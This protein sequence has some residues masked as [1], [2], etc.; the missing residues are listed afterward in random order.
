MLFDFFCL[1]VFPTGMFSRQFFRRNVAISDEMRLLCFAHER[2][3]RFY[4]RVLFFQKTDDVKLIRFVPALF[5]S[6]M[7]YRYNYIDFIV[8]TS[9]FT[10]KYKTTY[11]LFQIFTS[12]IVEFGYKVFIRFSEGVIFFINKN[13]F[14]NSGI[15]GAFFHRQTV[16][17]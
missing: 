11:L 17:L 12:R 13:V 10:V 9:V 3:T 15:V 2:A 1:Q 7:F 14:V 8:K 6:A 5:I 4:V 16:T